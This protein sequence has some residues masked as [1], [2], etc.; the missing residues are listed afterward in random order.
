MTTRKFHK[1]VIRVTVLS[2][3]PISEGLELD[4]IHQLITTGECSG[5]VDWKPDQV[6]TGRQ[7]AK[8]LRQQ[9]SDPSFFMLDNKG[10]EIDE[11]DE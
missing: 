7:A 8:A 9:G 1:R 10:D 6:I 11:I 2:E 4:T 5:E 3:E